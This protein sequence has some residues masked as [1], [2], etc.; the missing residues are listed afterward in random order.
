MSESCYR[1]TLE[2][3]TPDSPPLL[4]ILMTFAVC[5][6]REVLASSQDELRFLTVV[7]YHLMLV[8]VAF[9]LPALKSL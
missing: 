9:L 5:L 2:F 1:Y 3:N 8:H 6:E 4:L 7:M